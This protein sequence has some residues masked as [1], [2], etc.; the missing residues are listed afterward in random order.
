MERKHGRIGREKQL[1][2]RFVWQMPRN[3]LLFVAIAK[4]FEY[5]VR[6]TTDLI[7]DESKHAGVVCQSTFGQVYRTYDTLLYDT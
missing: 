7:L 1:V 6:S 5:S 2:I 3:F 4:T